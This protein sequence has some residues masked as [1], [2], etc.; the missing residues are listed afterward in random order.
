MYLLFILFFP[1]ILGAV[2]LLLKPKNAFL[3]ALSGSIIEAILSTKVLMDFSQTQKPLIYLQSWIPDFGINFS[4]W[5]DGINGI[6]IGLCALM[7]PFIIGST[8][9]T[10]RANNNQ[11]LGLILLMQSAL[12]GAFLAK[13]AFL[14]YFF[15]EASLLPIYFLA[16][17]YGGENKNAITFKFFVY[18]LFGSLFLLIGL[19]YVY[20]RTP[21][22]VH[23]ADIFDLYTTANALKASEQGLLFLSFF[24]TRY[25]RNLS[26]SRNHVAFRNHA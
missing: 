15:F 7:V 23:S 16:A 3:I 19:I 13:D 5:V 8:A 20:L 6:L 12:I 4:L 24:A 17:I 22:N 26:S 25:L 9:K 21:G 10:E 11:F 18:T 14:F 2:L 1:L